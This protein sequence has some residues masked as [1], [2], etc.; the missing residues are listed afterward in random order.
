MVVL[1]LL[2]K[3]INPIKNTKLVIA[4]IPALLGIVATSGV[5]MAAPL[6]LIEG[7]GDESYQLR[8]KSEQELALWAKKNGEQALNDLSDIKKKAKSPEVISRLDNV[9][10]GIVVYK[11]IAGTR[12]YMGIYMEPVMGALGVSRTVRNMPAAKAGILPED[13]IIWV[14][15]I[16]LSKKNQRVEEAMEFVQS[17]VKRKNAGEKLTL[18]ILRDGE[19]LSKTLKLAD[20]DKATGNVNPLGNNR[21]I[22]ILPLQ[23][24][25]LKRKIQIIPNGNNGNLNLKLQLEMEKEME[26]ELMELNKKHQQLLK[27]LL[28]K[29]KQELRKK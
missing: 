11:A 17:Y 13:K 19:K 9:I 26:K 29:K 23:G 7:L 28:Q 8:E 10:S 21:G 25:G 18:K 15:G 20:Y 24:G 3:M 1:L 2:N 12:G 27:E 22:Q 14:D 6:D 16:D 5:A 4:M